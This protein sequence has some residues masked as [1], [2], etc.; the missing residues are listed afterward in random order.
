MR[1]DEKQG[2]QP[3]DCV[4]GGCPFRGMLVWWRRRVVWGVSISFMRLKP[5]LTRGDPELCQK[6]GAVVRGKKVQGDREAALCWAPF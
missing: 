5:L 4:A 2:D 3:S 6:G 1:R